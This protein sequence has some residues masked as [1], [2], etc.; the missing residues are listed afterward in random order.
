MYL[1]KISETSP[2]TEVTNMDALGSTRYSGDA[3][4]HSTRKFHLSI[5]T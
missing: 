1:F 4:V 2:F 3:R 5:S